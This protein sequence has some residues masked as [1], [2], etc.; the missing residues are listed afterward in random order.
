MFHDPIMALC[1]CAPSSRVA[2]E[3]EHGMSLCVRVRG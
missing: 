2:A 3:E 1:P